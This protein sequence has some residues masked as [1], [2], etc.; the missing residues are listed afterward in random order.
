MYDGQMA[1]KRLLHTRVMLLLLMFIFTCPHPTT[2]CWQSSCSADSSGSRSDRA[3]NRFQVRG[4]W[5]VDEH[6]RVRL[7]HGFNSVVKGPPFIDSQIFNVTRLDL[8]RQWGFN[9]VRLG[10][11]WAGVEPKQ[12]GQYNNTYL[13]LLQDAVQLLEAHGLYVIL[14]MHQVFFRRME[15]R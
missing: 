11:M 8:Y 6:R 9:V 14:D 1:R 3:S 5:I 12:P 2:P 4:R 15:T 13:K 10:A 7:F